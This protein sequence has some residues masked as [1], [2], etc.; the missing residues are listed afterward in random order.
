[1]ELEKAKMQKKVPF[2]VEHLSAE[3]LTEKV[4]THAMSQRGLSPRQKSTLDS[5]FTTSQYS[6]EYKRPDRSTT[7]PPGTWVEDFLFPTAIFHRFSTKFDPKSNILLQNRQKFRIRLPATKL[8]IAHPRDLTYATFSF[9][10]Q[11]RCQRI[12][13]VRVSGDNRPRDL[14]LRLK[15]PL[16]RE[17]SI[18]KKSTQL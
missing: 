9:R 5:L 17:P 1:M 11:K 12:W 10:L 15:Q 2:K 18:R 13:R 14:V 8:T 3:Q 16:R 4:R 6:K 7:A